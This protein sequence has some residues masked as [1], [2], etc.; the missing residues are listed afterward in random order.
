MCRILPGLGFNCY[1]FLAA[2][3]VRPARSSV[4]ER[5][6]FAAGSAKPPHSGIP[7]MF[8]FAGRIRGTSFRF[9]GQRYELEAGDGL[10]NAI[11]GFVMTRPWRVIQQSGIASAVNF[12]RRS[13]TR[14]C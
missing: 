9:E 10:G 12:K 13:M 7:L 11:H 1:S 5:A 2:D 6:D 8:P 4:G 3:G 14:H